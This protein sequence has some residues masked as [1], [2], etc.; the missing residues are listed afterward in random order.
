MLVTTGERTAAVE[1]RAEM[2]AADIR[3]RDEGDLRLDHLAD[4]L[5]QG[6]AQEQRVKP[7]FQLRIGYASAITARPKHVSGGRGLTFHHGLPDSW[8][9][10][11]MIVCRSWRGVPGRCY[12]TGLAVTAC[13]HPARVAGAFLETEVLPELHA[14][15]ARR[16]EVRLQVTGTGIGPAADQLV[17]QIVAVELDGPLIF[18]VDQAQ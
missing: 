13:F 1:D 5:L 2:M 12:R 7:R 8:R 6:H 17:G 18:F 11:T 10:V 3:G 16:V 9:M 14:V 4:L 15:G